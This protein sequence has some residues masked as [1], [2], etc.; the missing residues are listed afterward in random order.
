MSIFRN[1]IPTSASL[2]TFIMALACASALRVCSEEPGA[3]IAVANVGSSEVLAKQYAA[4]AATPSANGGLAGVWEGTVSPPKAP[5]RLVT[6]TIV[7][8]ADGTLRP[9]WYDSIARERSLV[10]KSISLDGSRFEMI[11]LDRDPNVV[12]PV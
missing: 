1:V 12:Q 6:I 3:K 10:A 8:A 7:R 11:F 9:N 2:R 5:P 4:P